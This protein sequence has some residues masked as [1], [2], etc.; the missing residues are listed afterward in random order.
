MKK[1]TVGKRTYDLLNKECSIKDMIEN[2][3]TLEFQIIST[4]KGTQTRNIEIS[5]N[6]IIPLLKKL[7]KKIS[8]KI[9]KRLNNN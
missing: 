4:F 1:G 9:D 5:S 8:E 2:A 6:E 3:K 7:K